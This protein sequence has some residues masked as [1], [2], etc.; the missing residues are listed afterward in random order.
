MFRE[1][2][3]KRQLLTMEQ[4]EDILRRNNTGTLAVSGDDGYP[5]SVPVN[6]VY[7][8]GKIYIHGARAGHKIDAVKNCD[9]VSFSVIDR[10]TLVPE[11][12]TTYFAS[13]IV[14]GRARL[15]ESGNEFE[16]SIYALAKKYSPE[17][18][19]EAVENEV[20]KF[21]SS[22]CMICIDIEHMSGKEAIELVRQRKGEE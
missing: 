5:Y 8:D 14:F 16:A 2:R 13:A 15:L 4:T 12:F 7:S 3:R 22:L 21:R 6:Y 17:A 11:E 18:T 9:K 1:M 10:D 19:D 20:A